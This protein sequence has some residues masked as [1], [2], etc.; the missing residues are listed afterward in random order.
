MVELLLFIYYSILFRFLSINPPSSRRQLRKRFMQP[1]RRRI[2]PYPLQPR[3]RPPNMLLPHPPQIPPHPLER[4]HL[5]PGEHLGLAALALRPPDGVAEVCQAGVRERRRAVGRDVHLA[6]AGP[7]LEEGC[8]EGGWREV[9]AG[10][11]EVAEGED[12]V[13]SVWAGVGVGGEIPGG[14]LLGGF[15]LLE[16]GLG[17]GSG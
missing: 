15:G 6:A 16:L 3:P 1:Q 12:E 9:A 8:E 14:G 10:L 17:S 7:G 13:Y 5:L 4:P 2:P 11:L